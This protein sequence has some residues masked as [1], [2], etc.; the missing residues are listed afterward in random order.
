MATGTPENPNP[1]TGAER[2]AQEAANVTKG[3]EVVAQ[4]GLRISGFPPPTPPSGS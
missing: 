3:A 1:K 2:V 4:G